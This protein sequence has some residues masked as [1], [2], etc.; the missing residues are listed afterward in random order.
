M[1]IPLTSFITYNAS[2]I[3]SLKKE[4]AEEPFVSNFANSFN[5][6]LYNTTI[7]ENFKKKL[8]AEW[9]QNSPTFSDYRKK[10]KAL[11]PNINGK[12]AKSSED[13]II[14]FTTET[15]NNLLSNS[16][17]TIAQQTGPDKQVIVP[18]SLRRALFDGWQKYYKIPYVLG[19]FVKSMDLSIAF[20]TN[21]GARVVLQPPEPPIKKRKDQIMGDFSYKKFGSKLSHIHLNL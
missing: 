21:D 1:P 5:G 17:E 9:I 4:I 7:D 11:V 3:A 14:P 8:F 16:L 20:T 10:Y 13:K 6:S 15:I 12:A 19:D 2:K 18:E